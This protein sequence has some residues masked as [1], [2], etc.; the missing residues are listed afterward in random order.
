MALIPVMP[1]TRLKNG[2][3]ICKI[4]NGM[5]Q[6]SGSHGNIVASKAGKLHTEDFIITM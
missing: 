1:T 5:W 6:I 4:T 2:L 3:K